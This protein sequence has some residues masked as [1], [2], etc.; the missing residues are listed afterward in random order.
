MNCSCNCM[1]SFHSI[2]DV[3]LLAQS[4]LIS[5]HIY[6]YTYE[7]ITCKNNK[8]YSLNKLSWPRTQQHLL[9]DA[10]FSLLELTQY[11]CSLASLLL[12]QL[13]C[14]SNPQLHWLATTFLQQQFANFF[15]LK[16]LDNFQMISIPAN[17][18]LFTCTCSS[19]TSFAK[20]TNDMLRLLG[21]F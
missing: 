10:C 11:Q 15:L 4:R 18:I 1:H 7:I 13:D 19:Q 21:F 3:S 20:F 16:C 17:F 6:F 5:W 12:F 2:H 8:L 9:E 14:H